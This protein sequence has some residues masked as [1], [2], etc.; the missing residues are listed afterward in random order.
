MRNK[1][2]CIICPNGCEIEAEA[3]GK[4][5]KV[6]GNTCKRGEEYVRKEIFSPER[7]LTT[8]VLVKDGRIPL[9]SAKLTKPVQ[10]NKVAEIMKEIKGLEFNAPVKIGQVL[11]KN[12]QGTGSDLIATK[13]IEKI[14]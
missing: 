1:Y 3:S 13:T 6:T 12:I 14:T 10:K 11:V 5:V 7:G 8:T 4:D 2:I 9:A